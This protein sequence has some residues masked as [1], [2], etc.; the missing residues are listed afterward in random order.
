MMKM[1]SMA[2]DT[3]E[4]ME[5]QIADANA[6]AATTRKYAVF[7]FGVFFSEFFSEFFLEFFLGFYE[8]PVK[9]RF[10]EFFLCFF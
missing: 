8:K 9:F 2:R 4:H 1:L 7:F 6:T 10:T 5:R 3:Q